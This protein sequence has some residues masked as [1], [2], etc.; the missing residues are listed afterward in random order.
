MPIFFKG[1][2]SC[3]GTFNPWICFRILTSIS[4]FLFMEFQ[5]NKALLLWCLRQLASK[6]LHYCHLQS[7]FFLHSHSSK[8]L[9]SRNPLVW[10][11][12]SELRNV[13]ATEKRSEH[14][15]ILWPQSLKFTIAVLK[16][17]Y[18][19][20]FEMCCDWLSSHFLQVLSTVGLLFVHTFPFCR[21]QHWS[22][23]CSP[24][25]LFLL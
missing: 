8:V 24:L 17:A 19:L 18:C 1:F 23:S 6:V 10:L 3:S 16:W 14:K 12:L 22:Q 13:L 4:E 25:L 2:W 9:K 21:W 11:V 20:C 15:L 7:L 5:K